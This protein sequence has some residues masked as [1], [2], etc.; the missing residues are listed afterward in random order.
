MNVQVENLSSVRRRLRFAI[1]GTTVTAAFNS[2]TQKIAAKAKIPGFRPGKAPA[3]II[4]RNYGIEVRRGVLD[5]LLQDNV[6]KAIEASGLKPVGR[7]EVE[8]F[9]DLK[10]GDDMQVAVLLEI[11]PEIVLT[12]Y[13][14]VELTVD[15]AI[16]DE[17][18][19]ALA[20]EHKA[21]QRAEWA[22]VED[23]AQPGDEVEVD[24][25]LTPKY[26]N[27][28]V[29][30]TPAPEATPVTAE[31]RRFTI[32][33]NRVPAQV[34]QA[35]LGAKPGDEIAKE[36]VV[37]AGDVLFQGATGVAVT[38]TV[39]E[40][41]RLS[42]PAVDDELAKDLGLDDLDAL[43][44]QVQTEI[45][46]ELQTANQDLRRRAAV[47]H[48]LAHN[49]IEVPSSI[50]ESYAD[51][52]LERTFGKLQ[53]RDLRG[54][55]HI[56]DR[57]RKDIARDAENAFRRSLALGAV[58]KAAGIEVSDEEIEKHIEVL[59]SKEPSRSAM[60]R[61]SYSSGEGRDEVQRRIA[62]EK[63]MDHLAAVATFTIGKR[64]PLHELKGE[65]AGDTAGFE[66]DD[67]GSDLDHDAAVHDHAGHDHAGHDHAGHD[68]DHAGHDHDHGAHE[69]GH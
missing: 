43:R 35:V 26:A 30:G 27:E 61:H 68:H 3:S 38:V 55:Q 5:K 17:S 12:G 9:S 53:Q 69:H 37:D 1:P 48:L 46:K 10:R 15:E 57:L 36:V 4:E 41:Q 20:L 2:A 42:I 34:D 66:M 24:Y 54:V 32:G 62:N 6:F 60:I 63:A 56:I 25:T 14:G 21:R 39:H 16:A 31:K 29:E 67:A 28:N 7:P 47:D 52:Q 50:I 19:L 13:E 23:G 8:S 45:D 49:T 64:M 58:A 44:A 11:L 40:V 18:E 59:A 65:S 51:E 22:P 33:D